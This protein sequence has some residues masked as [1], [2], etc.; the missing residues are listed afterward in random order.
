[1]YSTK[2]FKNWKFENWLVKSSELPE[3]FPLQ[4]PLLGARNSQIRRQVLPDFLRRQLAE[5]R[6]QS[7][8]QMEF[9]ALRV[10]RGGGQGTGPYQHITWIKGAGCDATLFQD[11]D[12]KTYAIIPRYNIDVQQIDLSGIAQDEVKLIGKPQTLVYAKT[13]TL[14]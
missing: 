9:G 11:T 2:N 10:C 3:N 12:G 1:M 7:G 4:A 8:R 13:M 5:K 6:I 14:E